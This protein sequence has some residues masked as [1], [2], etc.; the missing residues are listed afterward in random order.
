MT[1][2][3]FWNAVISQ[4]PEILNLPVITPH[5]L[6]IP[7][8]A[9]HCLNSPPEI[10]LRKTYKRSHPLRALVR[11]APSTQGMLLE[12]HSF[13]LDIACY[14]CFIFFFNG[15]GWSLQ[16]APRGAE[17]SPGNW[18]ACIPHQSTWVQFLTQASGHSRI[19]QSNRVAFPSHVRSG[20]SPSSWLPSLP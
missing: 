10:C 12:V 13:T 4:K 16:K 7:S 17:V 1:T 20:L 6:P 5:F 14:Q 8:S 19:W 15:W 9:N 11:L 3:S 2:A 18:V